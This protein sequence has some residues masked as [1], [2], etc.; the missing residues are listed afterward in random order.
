MSGTGHYAALPPLGWTGTSRRSPTHPLQVRFISRDGSESKVYDFARINCSDELRL[1][2]AD[3]FEKAT[4]S[5]GSRHTVASAQA[6]RGTIGVFV[7][8][9]NRHSP[10]PVTAADITRKHVDS[11]A[12]EQPPKSARNHL[13]NLRLLAR[14]GAFDPAAKEAVLSLALPPDPRTTQ[15][16]YTDSLVRRIERVARKD[17]RDAHQRIM[18]A[19]ELVDRYDRGEMHDGDDASLAA[20]LSHARRDPFN[21]PA[22][23][24]AEADLSQID[25]LNHLHLTRIEATAF[26]VLLVALTGANASTIQK[27]PAKHFRADALGGEQPAVA[28]VRSNK[29]RLGRRSRFNKVLIDLPEFQ[30]EAEH[31]EDGSTPTFRTAA[32]TYLTLV[33]LTAD[34]RRASGSGL[35]LQNLDGQK[36]R[37]AKGYD[38]GV[39]SR[40]HGFKV[41]EGKGARDSEVHLPRLRRHA[42]ERTHRPNDNSPRTVKE[43]YLTRSERTIEEGFS[44][45]RDALQGEERK[46]RERP[47]PVIAH[48]PTD[49][50]EAAE[51]LGTT[52]DHAQAILSGQQDTVAAACVDFR[53]SPYNA[54]GEPC[55]ASFLTCLDCTNARALPQHMPTQL[56]LLEALRDLR[57][58]TP[59]EQWVEHFAARVTQ[60]EDILSNYS[61]A[62]VEQARTKVTDA[63]RSR[64]TRLLQRHL[65]VR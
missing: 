39:W 50:Q 32:E 5:G 46:A 65:E 42:I 60:L 2:F 40:H 53:N 34:T 44:V 10:V 33:A 36:R 14:K 15:S 61:T 12:L 43:K 4:G 51:A 11:F 56:A 1:R 37:W 3:A 27:W 59:I 35:A 22:R 63:V 52:P 62:E 26:M 21:I 8:S 28:I 57:A 38:L 19:R 48:P 13:S 31:E 58:T 7:A 25:V 18:R 24:C 9:L 20:A 47:I 29:P 54:P 64:V 45:V 17:L 41:G 23:L 16:S 6:L 30:V 49:P 55:G